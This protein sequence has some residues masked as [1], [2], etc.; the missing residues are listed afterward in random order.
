MNI[1]TDY[2]T[3]Y[4]AFREISRLMHTSRSLREVQQR[5]VWKATE[6]LNAKGALLRILNPE[7]EQ[8]E[9]AAAYGLGEWYL[10]KGSVST[11]KILSDLM[12]TDQ[13]VVIDDIW[14]DPRVEYRKEAWDEGVRMMLDVPLTLD[15]KVVGR[16][17]IYLGESRAFTDEEKSFMVYITEQCACAI[18]KV[19]F[20]ENQRAQYD[21]LALQ[22]EKLSALG[23]MAAGIAH[24][25]NNPLAGILLFSSNL[26]KKVPP[27]GPLKE[28]LDVITR[29]TVRCKSI[30]QELLEF[31]RDRKPQ[32]VST[33]I[34]EVIEKALSI[35]DN[36]FRLKHL[37]LEK[38]LAPQMEKICVDGNQMEQ[39]FVNILINAVQA[40]PE[41]GFITV[42]SAWLPDS[43]VVRIQIADTG[44][45][46]SAK[47][48]SKVFEPFFSTKEKGTGLGLAVS[49]GIV[50]G[51][52]GHIR[53]SSQE[54]AGAEFTI[55][56]PSRERS[57]KSSSRQFPIPQ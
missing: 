38:T 41:N 29:E 22:T 35:L 19:R 55:D 50:K 2:K 43:R 57:Q 33:D 25:I 21:Q 11:Q 18:H 28:G 34:N 49:Y 1:N 26:S 32:M 54:G 10:K 8:F 39:V 56:L 9:V 17:R 27:E 40:T 23:R 13:V 47:N 36:E 48:L 4:H 46:I 45:G 20:I 14:H 53:V 7:T 44:C 31:S 42:K 15:D 6:I 30:I 37:Q 12:G 5:T 52:G 16:L 3:F 51:H 24:E